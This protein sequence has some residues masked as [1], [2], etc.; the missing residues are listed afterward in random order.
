MDTPLPEE[1]FIDHD[2]SELP[3]DSSLTLRVYIEW[4]DEVISSLL[5]YRRQTER[6]RDLN[7]SRF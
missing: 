1:C 3:D 4:V 5:E 7:Q 6:C 2:V